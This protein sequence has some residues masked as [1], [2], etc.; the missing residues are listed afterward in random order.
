LRH[1]AATQ[2][3]GPDDYQVFVFFNPDWGQLHF[4]LVGNAFAVKDGEN[5]WFSVHRFLEHELK[6]APD[7][8]EALHWTVQTFDQVKERGRFA[9]PNVYEDINDVIAAVPASWQ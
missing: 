8:W 2:N 6:D 9:I 7:L 5:P 1:Y 3:W 4:I